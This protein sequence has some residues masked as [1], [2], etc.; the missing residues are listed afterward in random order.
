MY[1][2][3]PSKEALLEE[4]LHRGMEGLHAGAVGALEDANTPSEELAAL[5]AAHVAFHARNP[6]T[7]RV[8]DNDFLVLAGAARKLALSRRDEY[9]ALWARTL[10]AGVASG[11]FADRGGVDRLA[12]LQMCTGVA[13]WY[14]PR[15]R[16]GVA[17]L[18]AQFADMGLAL[19]RADRRGAPP[20]CDVLALG[21]VANVIDHAEI[22]I[23][24]RRKPPGI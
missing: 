12:L 3:A 7:A 1:Y 15:G 8:V 6:R 22:Q 10:A 2:Y 13:H 18:C 16:L 23:E 20:R 9:E 5:I 17:E 4:V 19:V 24:P 14:S 11:A 21:S